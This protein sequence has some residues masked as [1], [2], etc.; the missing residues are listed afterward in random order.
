MK[1]IESFLMLRIETLA[2]SQIVLRP[3]LHCFDC[4]LSDFHFSTT[5]FG[6]DPFKRKVTNRVAPG[7]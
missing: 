4:R 2:R 1:L 6:T 7:E 5:V 3:G